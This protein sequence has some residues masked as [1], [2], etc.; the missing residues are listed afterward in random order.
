M[1]T[2][3]RHRTYT[4]AQKLFLQVRSGVRIPLAPHMKRQLNS[5]FRLRCQG[6][7]R[8]AGLSGKPGHRRDRRRWSRDFGEF[9]GS[10]RIFGL[11]AETTFELH[12]LWCA[13]L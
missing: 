3:R 2:E 8:P 6:F 5:L 12:I 1:A 9:T 7:I 10:S 11:A 13:V 4:A